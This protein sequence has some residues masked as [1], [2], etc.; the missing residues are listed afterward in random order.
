MRSGA[1]GYVL[2]TSSAE[3]ITESIRR[4]YRGEIFIDPIIQEKLALDAVRSKK[5]KSSALQ[6]S[7][8]EQEVLELIASNLSSRQIAD[9]LFLSIRTVENHRLRLLAK[10]GVKN[11]ASAIKKA[12]RMGLIQ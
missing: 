1:A 4:V 5:E 2:K 7:N 10:L 8:R 6:L 12:M 3:L 9:Q 11:S